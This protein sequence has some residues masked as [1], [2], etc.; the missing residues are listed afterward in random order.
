MLG[1][2]ASGKTTQFAGTHV[3]GF[4]DHDPAEEMVR[5]MGREHITHSLK[6]RRGAHSRQPQIKDASRRQALLNDEPA[7]VTIL[8]EHDSPFLHRQAEDLGI[9]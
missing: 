8:R 2:I 5:G 9:V 7:E 4:N 3:L 1:E 6:P